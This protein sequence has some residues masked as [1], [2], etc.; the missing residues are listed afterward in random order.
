MLSML[1]CVGKKQ[2]WTYH[3]GREMGRGRERIQSSNISFETIAPSSMATRDAYIRS[4][5]H[6][7]VCVC[8]VPTCQ[9]VVR[10]RR[11]NPV[12]QRKRFPLSWCVTIEAHRPH[13]LDGV[14]NSQRNR[15]E[16][17]SLAWGA[18]ELVFLLVGWAFENTPRCL[19]R[20]HAGT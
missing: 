12:S 15:P 9:N 4:F 5:V 17:A 20:V 18:L 19:W 6:G 1:G 16:S 11:E 2:A 14:C 7:P 13:C 10:A 3:T 8:S